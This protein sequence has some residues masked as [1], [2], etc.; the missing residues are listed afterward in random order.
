MSVILRYTPLQGVTFKGFKVDLRCLGEF[1]GKLEGFR[2]IYYLLAGS[3]VLVCGPSIPIPCLGPK[4]ISNLSMFA[5][6]KIA[7]RG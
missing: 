1:R 2:G 4:A 7:R 5:G 3:V 6:T